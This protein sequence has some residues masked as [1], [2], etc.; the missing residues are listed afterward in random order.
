M[1]W[2]TYH[3]PR[4]DHFKQ[5][6]HPPQKEQ[7]I[8]SNCLT[9]LLSSISLNSNSMIFYFI[10]FILL[11]LCCFANSHES[12]Y[13]YYYNSDGDAIQVKNTQ[14][15]E[16]NTKHDSLLPKDFVIINYD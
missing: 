4:S 15:D 6:Q 3:L 10:C 5:Q 8:K 11:S 1:T 12:N 7:Q 2:F 13:Y 14:S 16:E 9:Q